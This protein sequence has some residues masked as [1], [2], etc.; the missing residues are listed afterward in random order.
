[1]AG[2]ILGLAA[3]EKLL[4]KG[5]PDIRVSDPAKNELR[6]LLEEHAENIAKIA[7]KFAMHAGRKT[8]KAED[9]KLASK[10]N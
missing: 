7:A 2:K 9:V 5:A 4:K 6:I 10:H 8:I 1:M 3:M